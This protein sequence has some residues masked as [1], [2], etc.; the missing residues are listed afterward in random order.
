MTTT[1][2]TILSTMSAP[3]T[4]AP[5]TKGP[6]YGVALA[7]GER[8]ERE[9][10]LTTALEAYD[11]ALHAARRTK[12]STKDA[13]AAYLRVEAGIKAQALAATAVGATKAVVATKPAPKASESPAAKPAKVA[14][15]KAP[16]AAKKAE[17]APQERSDSGELAKAERDRAKKNGLKVGDTVRHV[18]RGLVQAECHYK[19]ERLWVYD[20]RDFTS[21][22]AAANACA[23]DLGAKSR[24]LN[25]WVFWGVEKR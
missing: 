21:I 11:E 4:T 19:A 14:K 6:S 25:G 5:T 13:S 20:G 24:S 18:Y 22:S 7:T 3:A 15:A 8:A 12:R 1:D 9:G 2:Q 10:Y 23:A 16:A 17:A